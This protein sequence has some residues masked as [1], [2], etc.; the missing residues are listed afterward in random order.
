M[1]TP[2]HALL[3]ASLLTL[4]P[5]AA[6]AHAQSA[7]SQAISPQSADALNFLLG[8]WHTTGGVPREGGGYTQSHGMLTG[9]R[10]FRGGPGESILVRTHNLPRDEND[11][12]P[13]NIA[14]FED[15]SI[16]VFHPQRSVWSGIAHNTLGNRKWR[17]FVR[18]DDEVVFFQRGELFEGVVGDIRFTYYD[19]TETSFEMRIDYRPIPEAEWQMGTYR[20]SARRAG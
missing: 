6:G 12:N 4:S 14:F 19:I 7:E 18:A 13:F 15:I 3:L 16:Y 17:D 8:V 9:E 20:M 2:F 11:D 5:V 10:A 1:K